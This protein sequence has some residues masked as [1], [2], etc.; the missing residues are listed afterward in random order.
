MPIILLYSAYMVCTMCTVLPEKYY[1]YLYRCSCICMSQVI[2]IV[3]YLSILFFSVN[4]LNRIDKTM[5]IPY[6]HAKHSMLVTTKIALA[7]L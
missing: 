2:F 4:V 6:C 1:H 7:I 5:K 3:L